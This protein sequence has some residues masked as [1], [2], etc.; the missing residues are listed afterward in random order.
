MKGVR[1]VSPEEGHRIF[2]RLSRRSTGLSAD[3]FVRAFEE[4]R[5]EERY[6]DPDI[7]ELLILLPLAQK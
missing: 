3:A 4:G 1:F 2:D 7:A 6:E 5:L